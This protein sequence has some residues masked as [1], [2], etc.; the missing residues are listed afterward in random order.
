[1]MWILLLL[2][3]KQRMLNQRMPNCVPFFQSKQLRYIVAV[4]L[5][6]SIIAPFFEV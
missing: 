3:L 4:E 1:M 5:Q 6:L 2:R